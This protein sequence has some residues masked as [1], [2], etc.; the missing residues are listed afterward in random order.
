MT[1]LPFW[2]TTPL[3]K[4][5]PQQWESLCDGCAKCCLHKLEDVD[6]GKVYY[7]NVACRLLD[8]H[9][10][11]CTRYAQR[12]SLVPTCLIIDKQTLAQYFYL[13]STCAYRLIAQ[14][15]DLLPWHPLVSGSRETVHSAG[16]SVRGRVVK[17]SADIDY[18]DHV[19]DWPV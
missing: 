14:G 19:V 9:Q 2:K 12:T 11:R 8:I 16:I 18:Q 15:Q 13:P 4:M 1:N 5:T 17:E 10:C 6:D 3:D 7:T